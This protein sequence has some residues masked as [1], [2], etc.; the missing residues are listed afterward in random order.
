MPSLYRWLVGIAIVFVAP[1]VSAAQHQTEGWSVTVAASLNGFRGA[2]SDTSM[3]G[4]LSIRPSQGIA[5]GAAVARRWGAW[6]VSL[7]V[8][9]LPTY[10]EAVTDELA[11]QERAVGL[12]R[13]RLSLLVTR[14]VLAV[15]DG[16]LE[17]RAGPS[18]DHWGLRSEA[19]G[20]TVG[21]GETSL[22]LALPAGP[23][24]IEHVFA[25]SWSA[26]PFWTAEL[27]ANYRR[28]DLRTITAGMAVRF[29]L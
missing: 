13:V 1:N 17:V 4:P 10:V 22:V 11:V 26:G 20:R 7:G 23:V 16:A 24:L 5:L 8:S 29:R 3:P 15:G 6:G 14:R 18:L 28:E 9:H 12:D 2:A 25:Y 27:P 21:G 19:G